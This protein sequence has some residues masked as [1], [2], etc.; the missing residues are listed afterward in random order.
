MTEPI[1]PE[2]RGPP[3]PYGPPHTRGDGSDRAPHEEPDE[4]DRELQEPEPEPVETIGIGWLIVPTV[5]CGLLGALTGWIRAFGPH[6]GHSAEQVRQLLWAGAL[7]GAV[8]GLIAGGVF[9]LLVWVLFPYKGRNPHAPRP[10]EKTDQAE[11]APG[12]KDEPVT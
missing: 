6:P 4:L 2:D 9:G 12:A 5:V 7:Q 3:D 10:E 1:H 8:V 11:A